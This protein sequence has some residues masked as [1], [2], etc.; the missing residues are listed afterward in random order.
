MIFLWGWME[1]RH[2]GERDISG[3]L[4]TPFNL[5]DSRDEMN[6]AEFPLAALADR[7]PGN[8]KTLVFEDRMEDSGNNEVITRR[9]TITASD[10]FGLP[11]AQDDEVIV[12]LMK[13]SKDG[14]FVNPKV[15]F[16]R[17]Q[18]I[19]ILGWRHEGRSYDRLE[20]SLKRWL[21]VTLY[22]DNAWRDNETKSWVSESFHLLDNLTL[23]D[24]E[25]R[26]K[27]LRTE[28]AEPPLSSFTWNE[29]VFRSFKSNYL[30]AIDL[31]VFRQ[32]A[33]AASKRMYRFLGKRFYHR[34]RWE[35][36]LVEFACEHIGFGRNYDI[37]QLKRRLQPAIE[38]LEAIG[39][40]EPLPVTGRYVKIGRG[41]WMIVF[42]E[43]A[44]SEIK[45]A[46]PQ[47]NDVAAKLKDRGV[48]PSVAAELARSF[49]PELI[50]TQIE[51]V[52]RLQK[53]KGR[54]S[55]RN[56]AGYLVKSIREGYLPPKVAAVKKPA[57]EKSRPVP[58]V[59]TPAT[60]DP[61]QQAIDAYLASLSPSELATLEADALTRT[62]AVLADG[63]YRSKS[64]NA[65][66]HAVYRRMIQERE[67][68]RILE[69]RKQAAQKAS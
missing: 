3:I 67:A 40:L 20:T 42:F 48:T 56:P 46:S 2:D 66:M 49:P 68:G 65:A 35:F 14:D 19:Q 63:Y 25:R 50:E 36:D 37:G 41:K 27:R 7:V 47:Q 9:L 59:E 1:I 38:E 39:F 55:I 51:V 61:N 13:L 57:A 10:K 30:R 58:V 8:V 43:K 4:T 53:T 17:Y 6:F 18:L 34:P 45:P 32:L 26:L 62:D 22:Y 64:G 33:H 44:P 11:T 21:G 29:V 24:Q 52:D 16:T 23:Y 31:S 12:G 69:V 60:I 15:S 54:D 28:G 5:S